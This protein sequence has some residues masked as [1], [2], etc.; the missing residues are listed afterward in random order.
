M[1]ANSIATPTESPSDT[2]SD[3]LD[4]DSD[5]DGFI[6]GVEVLAGTDPND[7]GSVP[8]LPLVPVPWSVPILAGLAL[9]G[10]GARVLRR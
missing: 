5:D 6:D 1:A 9:L 10:V 7:A 2:G 8:S 3:P 4:A